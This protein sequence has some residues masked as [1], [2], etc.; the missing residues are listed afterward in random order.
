MKLR[1]R[2]RGPKPPPRTPEGHHVLNLGLKHGSSSRVLVVGDGD[3]SFSRALVRHLAPRGL[4]ATVYDDEKKF[5]D[6]YGAAGGWDA[7]EEVQNAG[8][9]GGVASEVMYGVDARKLEHYFGKRVSASGGFDR[10]VFMFPQHPPKVPKRGVRVPRNEIKMHRA[11]LCD[12][13]SSAARVLAPDGQIWIT[14]LAGQGGTTVEDALRGYQNSWYLNE[15]AARA[16]LLIRG[17][18][19]LDTTLLAR[20][21]YVSRGYM[22]TKEGF[23]IRS[24]TEREGYVHIL[25]HP[26]GEHKGI[27][28]PVYKFDV[29]LWAN[30]PVPI[31]EF[32]PEPYLRDQTSKF[33]AEIKRRVVRCDD[34]MER[35]GSSDPLTSSAQSESR[36]ERDIEQIIRYPIVTDIEL[37]DEYQEPGTGRVAKGFRITYTCPMAPVGRTEVAAFHA[38]LLDDIETTGQANR[39]RK[40]VR[41]QNAEISGEI[42]EE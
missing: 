5:N 4:V 28:A 33:C 42:N 26:D 23:L 9:A 14:L 38:S 13:L 3:F 37:R 29:S 19:S 35:K 2:S 22:N 40:K 8:V 25:Q 12:F 1:K 39:D 36:S 24:G 17:V 16:H 11:L 18:H 27:D 34:D 10:I 20:Y 30:D 32:D 15:A 7:A 21:G 31:F 41:Q 6:V